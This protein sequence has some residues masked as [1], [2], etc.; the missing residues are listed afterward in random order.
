VS[1]AV[2]ADQ[3]LA[4][5]LI[6]ISVVI[7]TKNE[8][9]N[10]QRCLSSVSWAEDI[11]VI[12][13]GSTDATVRIAEENGARVIFRDFDN[14]ADQRNYAIDHGGLRHDWVLHLDADEEVTPQLKEELLEITRNSQDLSAQAYRVASRMILNSKWLR[15][16]GM[17]PAYQVRL[18]KT[19]ALRFKMVGHGQRETLS[20][21]QIGTLQADLIHHNFSKGLDDWLQRHQ[22]YARDEAVEMIEGLGVPTVW[23]AVAELV[24]ARDKTQR[25]RALKQVAAHL[26]FR[27]LLRFIYV[28]FLR[29]GFLDG[30]AGFTYARLMWQYQRMIDQ[31][32]DRLRVIG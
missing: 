30:P 32:V 18:G 14:F 17:Y 2:C 3:E 19:H 13:S 4:G 12:D 5:F 9:T 29:A 26:P 16:A 24:G 23:R 8:E 27:P 7:L 10:L 21:E 15:H 25:R 20:P 22:R 28:Y 31:E 6:L 11:L 1:G